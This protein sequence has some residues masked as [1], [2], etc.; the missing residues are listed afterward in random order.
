MPI[1]PFPCA[2]CEFLTRVAQALLYRHIKAG[3]EEFTVQLSAEKA[4]YGR[5]SLA[6][7]LYNRLF[8]WLVE[9]IN[10]AL[11]SD[12]D[13]A[14]LSFIG[15]LD[16]YGFEVLK[17]NYF[18][19]FCINYANEKLQQLFNSHVLKS[20][21]QEYLNEGLQVRIYA[22]LRICGILTYSC[23]AFTLATRTTRRCLT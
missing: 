18:E 14:L 5:D 4:E 12:I 22:S 1:Y 19:Q 2:R 9:R 16:I 10:V 20:E 23:R 7:L 11:A 3:V 21:Q 8:E 6:M 17:Q 13:K 15:I